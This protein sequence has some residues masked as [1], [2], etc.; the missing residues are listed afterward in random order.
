MPEKQDPL[1]EKLELH[2]ICQYED[3]STLEQFEKDGKENLFQ[4][5]LDTQDKIRFFTLV[6]PKIHI[7]YT[8]DLKFGLI[9]VGQ[10][11]PLELE[12]KG[13][14]DIKY[15]LINF[16]RVTRDFGSTMKALSVSRLY[17]LGWQ[18]TVNGKNIKRLMQIHPDGRVIII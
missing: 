7:T 14:K 16:R 5:V 8:V 13:N 15:R 9:F 1:S 17:F 18:A 6:N 4:K 12:T 3:G 10:I 11:Q 2:W